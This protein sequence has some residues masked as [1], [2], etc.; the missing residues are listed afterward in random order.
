MRIICRTVERIEDP[1]MPRGR[2]ACRAL[3]EL[4]RQDVVIGKPFLDHRAKHPLTLEVNVGDEIDGAFLVDPEP[5]R[6]AF[7]L[8]VAGAKDDLGGC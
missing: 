1:A 2:A 4:L 3:T 6:A 7:D 5:G 8:D